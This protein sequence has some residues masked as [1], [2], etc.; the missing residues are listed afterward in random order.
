M[1]EI[2]RDVQSIRPDSIG[3]FNSVIEERWESIDH[4]RI[5]G[6]VGSG[7]AVVLRGSTDAVIDEV[8]RAFDDAIGVACGLQEEP[9][10]LPGGVRFKSHSLAAFV[11]MQQQFLDVNN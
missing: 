1:P 9:K 8:S 2:V 11:F 3:E 4:V 7:Q 10:M 6:S 5:H